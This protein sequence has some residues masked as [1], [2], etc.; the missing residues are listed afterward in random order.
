VSSDAGPEGIE[1]VG[2]VEDAEFESVDRFL[3]AQRRLLDDVFGPEDDLS[4]LGSVALEDEPDE[5]DA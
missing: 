2:D 1:D 4:A 5:L 3:D